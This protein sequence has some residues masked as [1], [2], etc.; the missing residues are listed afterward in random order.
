MFGLNR[1][2]HR[3]ALLVAL[4]IPAAARAQDPALQPA[5]GLFATREQLTRILS[6]YDEA[7][8]TRGYSAE[9]RA[10]ANQEGELIRARLT[11]GDFQVG[12]EIQ[13]SVTGHQPQSGPFTV[14]HGR[15][16]TIPEIGDVQLT[17]LLRSELRDHL[18]KHI[19]R[20][21]RNPEVS[22]RSKIQ[23]HVTGAVG[24]NGWV[25]VEA[26]SRITDVFTRAGNLAATAKTTKISIKRGG[27]EIWSG[28]PLQTAI[29]QARTLDQLNLRAGD[30]II[31]PAGTTTSFG[32]EVLQALPYILTLGIALSQIL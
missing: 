3:V 15:I 19:A 13:I 27:E 6:E 26:D 5:T 7:R 16:I 25:V 20:F 9:I 31:V 17:G 8:N 18:T 12:D 28:E 10:M 29:A 32:R 4:A 23:L 2:A 1:N 22:V 11:E 21:I 30:Q 14:T 24:T